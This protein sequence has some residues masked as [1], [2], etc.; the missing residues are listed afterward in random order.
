MEILYSLPDFFDLTNLNTYLYWLKKQLPEAFRENV[1]IDSIYGSFPGCIWNGGRYQAGNVDFSV[2]K[3]IIQHFNDLNISLRFTFTNQLLKPIHFYDTYANFIL[4]CGHNGKN[5]VNTVS[6]EL[7]N[8]IKKNYPKYYLLNS[9]SRG[10]VDLST[11]NNMSK[12]TLTVLPY[13]LNHDRLILNN[14]AYPQNIEML[15]G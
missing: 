13:T 15:C 9:T 1:V 5:G 3:D 12:D 7:A 6:D 4:E 11:I 2:V 10:I 8:Y 14:L